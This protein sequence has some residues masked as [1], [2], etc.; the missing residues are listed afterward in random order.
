MGGA[1]GCGFAIE[2]GSSHFSQLALAALIGAI[3]DGMGSPETLPR[4]S[5]EVALSGIVFW[6]VGVKECVKLPL[7][8]TKRTHNNPARL[9]RVFYFDYLGTGLI[10]WRDRN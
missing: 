10:R 1:V 8:V 9:L 6:I 3:L 5:R 2:C 7:W 4:L